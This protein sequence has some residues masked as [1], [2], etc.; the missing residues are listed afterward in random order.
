MTCSPACSNRAGV[1]D[2]LAQ[3]E[4]EEAVDRCPAISMGA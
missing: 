4:G 2:D 1:V 3:L